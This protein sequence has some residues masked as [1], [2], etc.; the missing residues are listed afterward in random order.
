LG[1]RFELETPGTT[2]VNYTPTPGFSDRG[3]FV[4]N[5]PVVSTINLGG[6]LFPG[7]SPGGFEFAMYDGELGNDSLTINTPVTANDVTTFQQTAS[8]A[9]QFTFFAGGIN[10][11]PL[12]VSDVGSTAAATRVT[13]DDAGGTGDRFIYRGTPN[14]DAFLVTTTL[15]TSVTISNGIPITLGTA[16]R[17]L[18]TEAFSLD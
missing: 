7:A 8:D 2:T 17:P 4:I 3:V 9:G 13:I 10:L 5:Q 11:L 15:A 14:A 1:D 18:S 12:H 16:A 6:P